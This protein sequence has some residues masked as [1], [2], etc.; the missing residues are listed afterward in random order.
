MHNILPYL[1]DINQELLANADPAHAKGQR[2]FFKETI[3]PL[4]VRSKEL[5]TLAARRWQELKRLEPEQLLNL[6]D[7]LWRSDVFEE[8]VLA[9]KWCARAVSHL[10]PDAFARFEAW[11]QTRVGNWAHCDTLCSGCIGGLLIRH[12]ELADRLSHWVTSHNRWV[13]RGAAVSLVPAARRGLLSTHIFRV[14]DL[15]LEDKD[16]LV[17]KGYGWLLREASKARAD[18]V[19]SFVMTRRARMPRVALRCAIELLP[20]QRRAL[21]MQRPS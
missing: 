17:R 13:R 20:Q 18:E 4:G 8:P 2:A 9:S 6:C 19:F 5:N 7:A 3:N 15:L 21:A 12:P 11:L 10:G 16:D 14:A 1:A